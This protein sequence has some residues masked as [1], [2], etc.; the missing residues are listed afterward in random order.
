MLLD[1]FLPHLFKNS[2]Q[3][4]VYTQN[5]VLQSAVQSTEYSEFCVFASFIVTII[6]QQEPMK[7][8]L[9]QINTLIQCFNVL[10]SSTCFKPS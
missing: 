7:C 5:T 9:L 2:E 8:T 4:N 3:F 10:I 1:H 6:M